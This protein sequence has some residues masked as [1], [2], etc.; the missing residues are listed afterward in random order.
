MFCIYWVTTTPPDTWEKN[1]VNFTIRK[2]AKKGSYPNGRAI[3]EKIT[4]LTMK[5]RNPN[6]IKPEWGGGGGL[7][8]LATKKITV[9]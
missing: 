8:D 2:V 4:F 9:F 1:L 3:K 6:A 7:N 5:K